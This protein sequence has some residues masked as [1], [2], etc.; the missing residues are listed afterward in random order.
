MVF[1]A[2]NLIKD[3]QFSCG[4]INHL[5]ILD[6]VGFSLGQP[7]PSNSYLYCHIWCV[8]LLDRSNRLY[9][10]QIFLLSSFFFLETISFG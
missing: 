1:S 7:C 6:C 10:M 2:H 4:Y 9:S 3:N 8:L 5:V